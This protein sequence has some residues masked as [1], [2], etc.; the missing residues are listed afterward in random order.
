MLGNWGENHVRQSHHKWIRWTVS[1]FL[2]P[3][4]FY[5]ELASMEINNA[6]ARQFLFLGHILFYLHAKLTEDQKIHKSSC[7]WNYGLSHKPTSPRDSLDA[8]TTVLLATTSPMATPTT[9]FLLLGKLEL[10]LIISNVTLKTSFTW[11]TV[12]IVTNNT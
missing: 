3:Y 2:E 12:Y 10:S 1:L 11:S 5:P 4:L 9:L 7:L 8:A 6:T